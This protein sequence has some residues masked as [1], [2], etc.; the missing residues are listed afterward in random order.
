MNRSPFIPRCW[1]G[2]R[3]RPER[4]RPIVF[5]VA[6]LT[7][8]AL[9][10]AVPLQDVRA[11]K[12]I[13]LRDAWEQCDP[14]QGGLTEERASASERIS[15]CAQ[16]EGDHWRPIPKSPSSGLYFRIDRPTYRWLR[17]AL[18]EM[19]PCEDPAVYL[20]VVNLSFSAYLD[21]REIYRFGDPDLGPDG[22]AGRPFHLISLP[23]ASAVSRSARSGDQLDSRWLTL[24]IWSGFR[25]IGIDG[26]GPFLVC[27]SQFQQEIVREDMG[28]FLV[29]VISLVA[30]FISLLMYF[31]A[32]SETVYLAFALQC[33]ALGLYLVSHRELRLQ[34]MLWAEPLIW[35]TLENFSL[36]GIAPSVA[37]FYREMVPESRPIRILTL[38]ALL[39]ASAFALAN[40]FWLPGYVLFG[41]NLYVLLAFCVFG[42]LYLVPDS[43]KRGPPELRIALWGGGLY[44]VTGTLDILGG[45]GYLP[46]V[47]GLTSP[48]GFF[49]LLLSTGLTVWHRYLRTRADL[50]V[51]H[52]QL[53]EHS[54][55]LEELVKRRTVELSQTL[56]AVSKLKNEQ[57]ADYLLVSRVL[58]PMI[59]AR[60]TSGNVKVE[61]L[62]R[63]HKQF[64]FGGLAGQVGGDVCMAESITL[65]GESYVVWINADAMGKSTQGATGALVL[66][67]SF[68]SFLLHQ[69]AD[70]SNAPRARTPATW[71]IRL[72]EEI[73]RA[74][75]SFEG[76]MTVSFVLG[77]VH[78]KSGT[79]H[80]I[81]AGHPAPLL[82]RA[83]EARRVFEP[84]RDSIGVP[85][86]DLLS[87]FPASAPPGRG[88]PGVPATTNGLTLEAGDILIA[89]SD[90]CYDLRLLQNDRTPMSYVEI[91]QVT[92]G[93]L[94]RIR[95]LLRAAGE[96]VDDLSLLRLDFRSS[97]APDFA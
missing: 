31:R 95:E 72:V 80:A 50:V 19:P 55:N 30:F 5:H 62:V 65:A 28:R 48:F 3:R 85:T 53:R 33:L 77:L 34:H 81:N 16:P 6:T 68:R 49:V 51:A 58:G 40:I 64:K 36:Y 1:A 39:T 24:R 54:Q 89:G 45:L 86:S 79:V 66:A 18:S 23:T 75:R 7:T 2:F 88:L 96:P 69:S 56:A 82:L 87:D 4:P 76:R 60:I 63:Q 42:A 93:D 10:I 97:D 94:E 67:V 20:G 59:G 22:F 61:S 83:G 52:E 25:N 41:P 43:L 73:E 21:G 9:W 15:I 27:R 74:F 32:R 13:V 11:E 47:S 71:L 78:A 38:V 14:R 57:D 8:I 17:V 84:V 46:I 90:G 44:L 29:G 12:P 26:D 92:G 70:E 37:F 91:V 35:Y